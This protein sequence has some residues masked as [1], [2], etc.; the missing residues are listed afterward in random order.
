MAVLTNASD[1]YEEDV[2]ILDAIQMEGY[3]EQYL[4]PIVLYLFTAIVEAGY[5]Q[6]LNQV[7]IHF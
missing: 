5:G 2:S 7:G 6:S 1:A 4:D 3:Y